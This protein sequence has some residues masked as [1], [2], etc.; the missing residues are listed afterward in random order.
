[1]IPYSRFPIIHYY[2]IK[3]FNATEAFDDVANVLKAIEDGFVQTYLH[4]RSNA[5]SSAIKIVNTFGSRESS[6]DLLD[7]IQDRFGWLDWA[8]IVQDPKDF[9]PGN[10]D[11]RFLMS[12]K[13][14]KTIRTGNDKSDVRNTLEFLLKFK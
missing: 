14:C 6:A 11:D 4:C 8:V 3:G 9:D 5:V 2:T 10:Y 7:R 13:R 12:L 1:M